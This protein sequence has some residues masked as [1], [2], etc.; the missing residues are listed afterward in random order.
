MRNPPTILDAV[1]IVGAVKGKTLI[2]EWKK[3]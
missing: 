1:I 2:S 3:L